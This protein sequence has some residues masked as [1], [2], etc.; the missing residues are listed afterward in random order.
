MTLVE[1][2][3][4]WSLYPRENFNGFDLKDFNPEQ[5]K[6][7]KSCR[8]FSKVKEFNIIDR[9]T[10]FFRNNRLDFCDVKITANLEFT[11]ILNIMSIYV[12]DPFPIHDVYDMKDGL[13]RFTCIYERE[14]KTKGIV[15]YK[16]HFDEFAAK[17][18][19]L[20]QSSKQ[21]ADEIYKQ[22]QKP[23]EHEYYHT[24]SIRAHKNNYTRN[25]NIQDCIKV[26]HKILNLTNI[27]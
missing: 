13:S 6:D 23:F 12:S 24:V 25:D 19:T 10:N 5:I 22:L 9:E 3:Q 18:L 8:E 14:M 17:N 16:F 26:P 15:V 20:E 4:K 1:F 2:I 27:F 11:E 21:I 7:L